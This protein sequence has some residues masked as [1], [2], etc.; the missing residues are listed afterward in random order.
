MSAE[1]T[2]V[3]CMLLPLF[4]G[5]LL[6]PKASIVHVIDSEKLDIVVDLQ[7][8]IVGKIQWQGWTVPL[9]SFESVVYGTIPKYNRET[10]SVVIHSLIEDALRPFIAITVQGDLQFLSVSEENMEIV[11]ADESDFIQSKV[12]INTETE[13]Y[14]PELSVL[15]TYTAQYV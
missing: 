9:V 3:E 2:N 6:L 15:A 4:E 10:K 1:K 14:I 8:G 11:E 7:G 5:N 13:A 12:L